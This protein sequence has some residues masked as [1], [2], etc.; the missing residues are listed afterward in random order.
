MSLRFRAR[1][2]VWPAAAALLAFGVP[3]LPALVSAQGELQR[4]TLMLTYIPNIQ[5]A[6]FYVADAQGFNAERGVEI[7]IEHADEP[8]VVDLVASDQREFGVAGADQLIAAYA[9]ERPVLSVYQWFQDF[10]VAVVV[11]DTAGDTETLADLAGRR[12]GVPGRFGVTYSGLLAALAANGLQESDIVL[13]E[14][15]FNAPDVFCL[16][17]VDAAAVYVNNEP[18]QIQQRIDAGTCGEVASIRVF[19]VAEIANLA[20]NAIFVSEAY[21]QANAEPVANVLAAFDAALVLTIHNPARA[22]LDSETYVEGLPMTPELREALAQQAEAADAFLTEN[23]D[24]DR[25]ALA[26]R[27]AEDLAALQAEFDSDVLQQY[28]VLLETIPL[29]EGD[30]LGAHD[31]EAWEITQETLLSMGT[32]SEPVALSALYTDT[33]LP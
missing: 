15:G 25:E 27:R 17:V 1:Q 2:L 3:V 9:A 8:V 19:P 4:M 32:I 24:A 26:A 29:W 23:P 5:F 6:P 22:Y 31:A 33:F 16:G 14:I 18:L 10:P 30:R 12:V 20:S 21:A 7:V 28:V 13:E 11:N